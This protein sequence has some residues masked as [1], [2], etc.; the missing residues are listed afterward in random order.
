MVE[1]IGSSNPLAYPL[2]PTCSRRILSRPWPS[3][4][5]DPYRLTPQSGKIVQLLSEQDDPE[6]GDVPYARCTRMDQLILGE[7]IKNNGMPVRQ[8]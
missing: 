8:R 7:G 2:T 6:I 4:Q 5:D 1:L 3:V